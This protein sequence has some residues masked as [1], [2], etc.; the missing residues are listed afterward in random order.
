[1]NKFHVS[2]CVS[3]LLVMSSTNIMFAQESKTYQISTLC[4]ADGYW[5]M[6]S[7]THNVYWINREIGSIMKADLKGGMA[8]ALISGLKELCAIATDG[9]YVYWTEKDSGSVMAI[10]VNGGQPINLAKGQASPSAIRV[11]NGY[12]SWLTDKG[13]SE[14]IAPGSKPNKRITI[15]CDLCPVYCEKYDFVTG[16]NVKYICGTTSCNCH[17]VNVG[18]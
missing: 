3:L 6:A 18:D 8:I 14:A 5:N 15:H 2:I 10:P 1:M 17:P 7:D 9:N 4:N 12:V 16:N 13:S 11:Y